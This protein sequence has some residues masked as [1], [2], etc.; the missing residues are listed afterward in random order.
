MHPLLHV[1]GIDDVS[2]Y[3]YAFWSGI[4]GDIAIIGAFLTTPVVLYRKHNCGV[5]WCCRIARHD[6]T[7]PGTG[8][9]HALCRK[10]HPG[11]PG[12]KPV[13]AAHI[14]AQYHLYLGRAPGKG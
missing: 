12:R 14:Q 13:S 5:R 7:D 8:I 4:G 9:V 10:H 6:F 3:W 11:H 2:G 1:L